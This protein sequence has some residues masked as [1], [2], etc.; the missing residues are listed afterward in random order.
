[1]ESAEAAPTIRRTQDVE[2]EVAFRLTSLVT[3]ELD[4]MPAQTS[5]TLSD[6]LLRVRMEDA[7][8]PMARVVAQSPDGHQILRNVYALLHEASRQRT[9]RL[10]A[11][12][13]G[14]PVWRS[15]V[16]VDADSGLVTFLFEL[17]A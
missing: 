6:G 10:V 16:T 15:E 7:L 9:H 5:A 3:R 13:V 12:V 1:M 14:R 11:R 8:S 17:G 4:L 2:S